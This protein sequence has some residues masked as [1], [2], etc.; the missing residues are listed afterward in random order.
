M[1]PAA[2]GMNS[3]CS[4]TRLYCGPGH[5]INLTQAQTGLALDASLVV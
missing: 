5:I 1:R 4:G 2:R 3:S